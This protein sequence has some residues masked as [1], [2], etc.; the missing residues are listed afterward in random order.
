MT[1]IFASVENLLVGRL[2]RSLSDH[3]YADLVAE[4]P[5]AMMKQ[6]ATEGF[7]RVVALGYFSVTFPIVASFVRYVIRGVPSEL[8]PPVG[9]Y[10][11]SFV[12]I[13]FILVSAQKFICDPAERELLYRRQHGKWRWDH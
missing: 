10:A 7:W 9:V 11:I 12:A 6:L 13:I 8:G 2:R 4:I 1:A 3:M 5:T